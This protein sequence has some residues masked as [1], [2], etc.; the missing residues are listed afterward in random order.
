MKSHAN[1]AVDVTVHCAA[2]VIVHHG[3]AIVHLTNEINDSCVTD[4]ADVI[5]L[6]ADI[7]DVPC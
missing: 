7:T 2:D 4:I 1:N 6:H 3:T 5:A